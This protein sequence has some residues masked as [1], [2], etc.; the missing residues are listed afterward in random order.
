MSN[1]K[2]QPAKPPAVDAA[3][4]AHRDAAGRFKTGA[5]QA[6]VGWLVAN[7]AGSMAAPSR[8]C[9]DDGSLYDGAPY[10][11]GRVTVFAS[12]D[13]VGKAVN[14]P[15]IIFG[16]RRTGLD[17]KITRIGPCPAEDNKP[18]PQLRSDWVADEADWRGHTTRAR[19]AK[20][21][22]IEAVAVYPLPLV[23]TRRDN[24]QV[25]LTLTNLFD[26]PLPD[27]VAFSLYYEGGRKK[28]MPSFDAQ[29]VAGLAP[30]AS[31]R[32][33]ATLPAPTA[34]RRKPGGGHRVFR[35]YRFKGSV[36]NVSADL[37]VSLPSPN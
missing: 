5:G 29:P 16:Q 17:T 18:T 4:S 11:L 37:L 15:A 26:R 30:G 1:H 32:F 23:T 10:R 14:G 21:D 19:L 34:R 9:L 8:Y 35:G 3:G 28:P 25:E 36:G 13:A 2:P 24:G 6:H 33:S 27:S 22:Y 7:V 20:T 31:K 12:A